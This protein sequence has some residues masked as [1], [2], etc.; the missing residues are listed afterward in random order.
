M[1]ALNDNPNLMNAAYAR[2]R[3]AILESEIPPNT[4][5]SESELALRF[6]IGRT[7]IHEACLRL[8]EEGLLTI[9]AKKGIVI[10]ACAIEDLKEIYEVIIAL[11]GAAA[12]LIATFDEEKRLAVAKELRCATQAM[13]QALEASNLIAWGRADALFHETLIHKCENMRL[14]RLID[15]VNAQSHRARMLTLRLRPTLK[16][17]I[18]E[19]NTMCVAIEKGDVKAKILAEN[20][21]RNA[22]KTLIPLIENLGLKHF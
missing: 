2:L 8:Q 14:K 9:R 12:G 11:E 1:L 20:H 13:Q 4:Q 7:P 6:G 5:L 3:S 21:R 17:S 10:A 22:A 15:M 19:H 16:G 18:E